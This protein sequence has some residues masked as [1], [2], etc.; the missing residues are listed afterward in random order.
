MLKSGWNTN[1]ISEHTFLHHLNESV[2]GLTR[3]MLYVGMLFSSFC[4][5]TEDNY[6]FSVNYLHTGKAK[7]W[8]CV[9]SN[10]AQLFENTM[11]QFL[12]ELFVQN[13]NLL[14]LLVTQLSPKI[15]QQSGVPVYTG[16]Q[17]AGQF[18]VTSPR[19]YH[20]GF[21]TGFNMAESVNF[22]LESWLPYC[23]L[24]CNNYRYQR[25]AA[26]PY[27]EFVLQAARTPDSNV[28]AKVLQ[29]E[30]KSIIQT[31]QQLQ[32]NLIKEAGISRYLIV[33]NTPYRPCHVC[34][35][36]CYISGI[37]CYVHPNKVTCLHHIA[38]LCECTVDHK[39]LLIRVHLM[40]LYNIVNS[41]ERKV[42][43]I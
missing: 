2:A 39:V 10:Y 30:I 3:P 28:I 42:I 21:N 38:S 36:D 6:L 23:A 20:S 16:L 13:P 9:P 26:F 4:W 41:L 5:H 43:A 7:R 12:P 32:W 1:N 17:K 24:A 22:A 33:Q 34:G 25:V 14:H 18:V 35:Y 29:N 31:E 15:L 8:Y 27:E 40:E 11:R 37:T 19:S